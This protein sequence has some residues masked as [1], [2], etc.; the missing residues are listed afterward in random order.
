MLAGRV[1]VGR[2]ESLRKLRADVPARV[3]RAV[4]KALS[5]S[6]ADRFATMGAFKAALSG[7]GAIGGGWPFGRIALALGGVVLVVAAVATFPLWRALI[8]DAA[9]QREAK[10]EG[11]RL[12]GEAKALMKA[13]ETQR[14]EIKEA[15]V[16]AQRELTQLDGQL[17]SAKTA[18]ER[19]RLELA[20]WAAGERLE[21]AGRVQERAKRAYEG[22]DGIVA[23]EGAINAADAS[24]RSGT[25]PAAIRQ[26]QALLGVLGRLRSVPQQVRTEL[27][28][29]RAAMLARLDGQ[30][31]MGNCD[32]PSTWTAKGDVLQVY[33][34]ALGMAQ[35]QVVQVLGDAVTT[36]VT[37]PAAQRGRTYRYV[38][39]D[40][41][42]DVDELATGRRASLVRCASR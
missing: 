18:E 16:A 37:T 17:R 19:Q 15:F 7:V 27:D 38:P 35:E 31:G 20:R 40:T 32:A 39:R 3:S 41:A 29:A 4:D 1:P 13:L 28:A 26:Y 36:V 42:L 33:W 11:A 24:L 21:G 30:W 12:Q 5:Q 6:A 8:P 9:A 10:V 23:I 34:P 25:A 22:A 14:R 2:I